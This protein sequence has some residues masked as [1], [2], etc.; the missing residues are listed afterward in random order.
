MRVLLDLP[1]RIEP[2]SVRIDVP[3][4]QRRMAGE[5]VLLDVTPDACLQALAG[6]LAVPG[7][8][9]DAASTHESR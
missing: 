2:G 3:A 8:E 1:S 7:A 6:G 4:G 9:E 5:A